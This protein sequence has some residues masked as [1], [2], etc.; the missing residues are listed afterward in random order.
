MDSSFKGGS[1]KIP[2]PDPL[3][4]KA[5]D[6]F[7]R[8]IGQA[9]RA[10][11]DDTTRLEETITS[12]S[13]AQ[14]K[15]KNEYG[16]HSFH[17]GK[18]EVEVGVGRIMKRLELILQVGDAA[19]QFGP[20]SVSLVWSAFR[21]I[22]TGFL[23]DYEICASLFDAVDQ[24]SEILFVCQLYA[25]QYSKNK[26]LADDLQAT[27]DRVLEQIPP[28]YASILK[29]SYQTR[30][31]VNDHGKVVRTMIGVFGGEFEELNKTVED[32]KEKRNSLQRTAGLAFETATIGILEGNS[33][34]L[35]DFIK[36]FNDVMIPKLEDISDKLA[37]S[38][39]HEAMEKRKKAYQE[40]KAWLLT[41]SSELKAPEKQ[42]EANLTNRHPGTCQWV[43]ETP[44]Y[45]NWRDQ[46]Q[47]SLLYLFGEGGYGKSYLVSTIIEDLKNPIQKWINPKPETVYFF[48]KTGD[49]ATQYGERILLHL[50]MQLFT[51]SG[52]QASETN[53]Q[54][55]DESVQC[56]NI[57]DVLRK[58]RDKNKSPDAK[59]DS[60]RLQIDSMLQQTLVD[61]ADVI[62]TRLFV[63]VDAIDEC[64]DL[65]DGLLDTLK[66]LPDSGIDIR[67]LVSSRPEVQILSSLEKVSHSD[68]KVSRETVHDDL[69][70][71]IKESLKKMPRFR[72]LDVGRK[73]A[74]GSDGMFRYASIVIENLKHSKAVRMN[75]QQL[76]KRLPDGMNDLYKQK[77]QSLGEDDR[78]ILLTA[79]RWLMCS[80]GKVEIGLVADDIEHC[81]EDDDSEYDE[82]E[83]SD[84]T[85]TPIRVSESKDFQDKKTDDEER[86]SMK[87]LKAVGRDFLKFSSTGIIEVQH[88]SVRDFINSEGSLLRDPRICPECVKRMN[89][90]SIYQA[91][92]KHGH[93]MMVERIFEKLVSPSFQNKFILKGFLENS[94]DKA[95]AAS[96]T[97][98]P[99][100]QL[101]DTSL[102]DQL[103][104]ESVTTQSRPE[105]GIESNTVSDTVSFGGEKT[106]STI[107]VEARS[108]SSTPDLSLTDYDEEPPPR[109]ELA[110]WPRHLLAAEAAWPAAERDAVL[111]ERWGNL[112]NKIE[113]FL[114]PESPIFEAWSKRLSLWRVK[115]WDPLHVAANFGLLEIMQRLISSGTNVDISDED[116]WTPLHLACAEIEGNAGV[117]LLIEHDADVNSLTKDK[118]TPLA[119]LMA[120]SGPPKLFQYLLDHGAK[121]EIPDDDGWTCLHCAAGDSNLE[122]CRILLGCSTVDIDAQ[123]SEGNTPLHWMFNNPN[124][125]PE[126]VQVFLDRGAKVNVQNKNSEGPLYNACTVGNVPA[127][128]LLLDRDADIDDDNV[129][130]RTALHAALEEN[131]LELVKMLVKRGADMYHKDKSG[132]DCFVQAAYK[133]ADDILEF[134]LDSLKSQDS[135]TKALIS[136]DLHGDTPLHKSAARGNDRT[137]E[138]LLN[139]GSPVRMCS[140]HNDDGMTP[141]AIAAYHG[142]LHI[143]ETLLTNGA[144]ASA[145]SDKGELPLCS[146][147]EGWKK[148]YNSR[149]G[150]FARVCQKLASIS[151][152]HA[153]NADALDLAVEKGALELTQTLADSANMVDIHGWTPL[154]LADQCRQYEIV[155]SLSHYDRE[156]TIRSTEAV[157]NVAVMRPPSRWSTIAKHSQLILSE[158][159]LEVSCRNDSMVWTAGM[160]ARTD[161]PIAAGLPE[162][163]YEISVLEAAVNLPILGLG[164]SSKYA[165]TDGMPGWLGNGA[166][167]WGYHGDDGKKFA[168]QFIGKAYSAGYGPGDTVGC[169]VNFT[170]GTIFYTRNGTLLPTAFEGVGGRLYPTVGLGAE[171]QVKIRAN[172]GQQ[173]FMYQP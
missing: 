6:I 69:L 64:S 73:I 156:S 96:A 110:Q 26:D 20:E 165:N 15:I 23:K 86:E 151:T 29:F 137:V 162:Y 82:T 142:N 4:E 11:F 56:Q 171:H 38:Q 68:I 132:W 147:L 164:F 74:N 111:Q 100:V 31:L 159:G 1:G 66:V 33:K 173:P 113:A 124:A 47:P 3:W 81:Y 101:S 172:F 117:E 127:T 44:Q 93:L 107:Q 109:Y 152:D 45:K 123:D 108:I 94:K 5:R 58:A 51:A 106:D 36:T 83:N 97:L 60:S 63:I 120:S 13:L 148:D 130:G 166:P 95:N 2:R 76:M 129:F 131:N 140:Q 92:P 35:E 158:D 88:Q 85:S 79:L 65:K 50:I 125:L 160:I 169:G 39:Q 128:R 53:D 59:L 102:N 10:R 104:G 103:N 55:S 18:K 98:H 37:K 118:R 7:F 57:I 24:V 72:N 21:L 168:N 154:V 146:A 91:A 161:H 34:V 61:L 155:R 139:A 126:L 54:L 8:D 143:V 71:Y 163:Y 49:N 46:E 30:K 28:L 90:D 119:L 105:V 122:L 145:R 135:L 27:G 43:L 75:V 149:T 41:E 67:V 138:I 70:A 84:N 25:R 52:E 42:Y 32:A 136:R 150:D 141:L 114:K 153:A 144:D 80:E 62:K 77:L 116:G 99:T 14:N 89:R 167:S 16:K 78:E 115:P 22:F 12:L 40:L 121:P 19:M 157:G 170:N 112:Y 17:V 9:K 133:G 48:C 134:L 87:I